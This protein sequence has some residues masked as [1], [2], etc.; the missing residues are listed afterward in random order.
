[1]NP[2]IQLWKSLASSRA[3]AHKMQEY[4]KLAKFV[5]VK[6]IGLVEDEK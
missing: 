4:V 3:I 6:V 2:M 5:M 1:M